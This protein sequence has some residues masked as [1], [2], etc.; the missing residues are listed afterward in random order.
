MSD[1]PTDAPPTRR[2]RAMLEASRAVIDLFLERR[3]SDFSVKELAEHAGLSE[4]TFY[5]YFPRKEQVICPF[6]FARLEQ[7]IEDIRAYPD[8]RPL[9]EALVAAQ[10]RA[11]VEGRDYN[12]EAL[13]PVLN[14]TDSLRSVWLGIMS[15]AE[16]AMS[17]VLAE[18]MGLPAGSRRATWAAAVVVTAGR[19]A[20]EQAAASRQPPEVVYAELLTLLGPG[21]FDTQG[22]GSGLGRTE[23]QAP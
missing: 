18:R 10:T 20:I 2:E 19:V 17:Q 13:L 8:D 11:Y 1:L 3:T 12:W 5:R 22:S 16:V 14:E 7:I 6:I 21:L 9:H 23:Q 15:D 4:R